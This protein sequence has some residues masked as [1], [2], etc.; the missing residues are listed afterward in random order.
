MTEIDLT[1]LITG[2]PTIA[3]WSVWLFFVIVFSIISGIYIYHW[4]RYGYNDKYIKK[5]QK[6]YLTGGIAL[7]LIT[8]IAIFTY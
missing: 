5:A 1:E 8:A 4:R 7:L 2:I 6:I 3:L